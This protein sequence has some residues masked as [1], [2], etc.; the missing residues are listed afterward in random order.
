MVVD[1]D[2][3]TDQDDDERGPGELVAPA[4]PPPGTTVRKDEPT[5]PSPLIARRQTPAP[6]PWGTSP[7][8]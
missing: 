4:A 5:Y 1:E 2:S 8:G 7:H 6:S 3:A